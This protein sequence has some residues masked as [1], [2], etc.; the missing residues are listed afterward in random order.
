[1]TRCINDIDIEVFGLSQKELE[2][3]LKTL[4]YTSELKGMAFPVY[5]INHPIL[6]FI[7]ISLPRTE[8]IDSAML[9]VSFAIAI[10]IKSKLPIQ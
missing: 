5:I 6:G 8:K 3:K 4:G 7:D 9:S 10:Q 2:E 1:M